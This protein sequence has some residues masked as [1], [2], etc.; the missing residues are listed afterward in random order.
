MKQNTVLNCKQV[1]NYRHYLLSI[2]ENP[3]ILI[4]VLT[5]HLHYASLMR[6]NLN[7][8]TLIS[9]RKR[10]RIVNTLFIVPLQAVS[11]SLQLQQLRTFSIHLFS[12]LS[13]KLLFQ[14]AGSGSLDSKANLLNTRK[15]YKDEEQTFTCALQNSCSEKNGKTQRALPFGSWF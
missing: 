9:E 12:K 15:A 8:V 1:K 6:Q 2:K 14:V 5:L 7:A 13:E 10:S 3:R 4:V 11:R